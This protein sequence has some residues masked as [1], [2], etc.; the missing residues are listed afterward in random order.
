MILFLR[1]TP[2]ITVAVIWQV[3]SMR[4]RCLMGMPQ[5]GHSTP[6]NATI[7]SLQQLSI[8]LGLYNSVPTF[9]ET[10]SSNWTQTKTRNLSS[11]APER[12]G[13]LMPPRSIFSWTIR[14]SSLRCQTIDKWWFME[15]KR[16]ILRFETI[17]V[18]TRRAKCL[19]G[20]RNISVQVWWPK[21]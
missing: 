9:A 19:E 7:F 13:H 21:T 2:S 14:G 6:S 4:D 12:R 11:Q 16:T 10:Y 5:K 8:K 3:F 15:G 1:I 20:L 18:W 17:W